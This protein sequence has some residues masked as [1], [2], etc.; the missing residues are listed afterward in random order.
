MTGDIQANA[1]TGHD[2]RYSGKRIGRVMTAGI[3]VNAWTGHDCRYSGK[4]VDGS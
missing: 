4:R 1:W 3:Q 2:C